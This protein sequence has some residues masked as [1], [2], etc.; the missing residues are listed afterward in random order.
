M[1]SINRAQHT[2]RAHITIFNCKSFSWR[3]K[4]SV[5]FI[6]HTRE[7]C[8]MYSTYM[9]RCQESPSGL[10]SPLNV[11]FQVAMLLYNSNIVRF[12]CLFA[13]SRYSIIKIRGRERIL[14]RKLFCY[15]SSLICWIK[16]SGGFL[17]HLDRL[18]LTS[19]NFIYWKFVIIWGFSSINPLLSYL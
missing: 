6:K 8:I 19:N 13:W 12:I 1:L 16:Y 7:P 18:F 17:L 4:F 2:E 9:Y 11:C 10:N 3:G 15:Q 14:V 5:I